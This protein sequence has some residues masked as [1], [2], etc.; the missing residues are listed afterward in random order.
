MHYTV[1]VTEGKVNIQID[2]FYKQF[3][4]KYSII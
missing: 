3:K 1:R 2:T 4:S